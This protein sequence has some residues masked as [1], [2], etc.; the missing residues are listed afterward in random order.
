MSTITTTSLNPL[1]FF[2]LLTGAVGF[3]QFVDL[4]RRHLIPFYPYGQAFVTGID[5]PPS[6]P[7]EDA[8]RTTH[9]SIQHTLHHPA[10]PPSLP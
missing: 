9:H 8:L 6:P 1:K 10:K 2:D 4:L 7:Q 5:I 3:L